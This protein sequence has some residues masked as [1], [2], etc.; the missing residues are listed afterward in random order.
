MES[1]S[2]LYVLSKPLVTTSGNCSVWVLLRGPAEGPFRSLAVKALVL[3]LD[4]ATNQGRWVVLSDGHTT[5][6]SLVDFDRLGAFVCNKVMTTSFRLSKRFA[7]VV[8]DVTACLTVANRVFIDPTRQW[9]E[10]VGDGISTLFYF[11]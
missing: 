4:V 3:G 9:F 6:P 11:T 8:G 7:A 2:G 1:E 5:L 10:M